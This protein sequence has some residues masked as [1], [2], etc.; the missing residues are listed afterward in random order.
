MGAIAE[1]KHRTESGFEMIRHHCASCATPLF[2]NGTRFPEI[3]MFMVSALNNPAE[4]N[5]SFQ[6]W[7]SS[8]VSWSEISKEITRFPHGAED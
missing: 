1:Y 4:V 3:Q 2:V 7:C 6:I 8:Q 5:P